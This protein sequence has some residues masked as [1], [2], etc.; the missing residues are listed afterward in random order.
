[1][2]RHKS[3]LRGSAKVYVREAKSPDARNSTI[4]QLGYTL[5]LCETK[6]SIS[7]SRLLLFNKENKQCSFSRTKAVPIA[8]TSP[9]EYLH[10]SSSLHV[11]LKS[12][13]Q[14]V[15]PI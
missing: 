2:H 7:H 13:L 5:V 10:N 6:L 4:Y 11:L 8:A 15:S 12:L 14:T 9:R 1:M 3:C